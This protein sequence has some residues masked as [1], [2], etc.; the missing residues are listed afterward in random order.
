MQVFNRV[1][2][3]VTLVLSTVSL[4]AAN[5]DQHFVRAERGQVLMS[6]SGTG[7]P[8]TRARAFLSRHGDV[9]GMSADERARVAPTAGPRVKTNAASSDGTDLRM[10]RVETDNIGETHVRMSQFYDGL[11]VFGAEVVVHMNEK[12]ITGVNGAFVAGVDLDVMPRLDVFDAIEVVIGTAVKRGQRAP[13]V[14]TPELIVYR[15]G[16]LEGRPGKSVLAWS[17]DVTTREKSE[18]VILDAQSGAELLRY[19]LRHDALYRKIY[20]PSPAESDLRRKEGDA[21]TL[22]PPVDN[23][24]DFAGQAYALFKNAFGR[25]SYD[26]NG[27]TMRSVYLVSDFCPNAVFSPADDMTM[28][29]PGF[30]TDDVVA[31]EWGHAYTSQTH[32]LIYAYQSGA[33]NESYSDIWGET[34]DL[35]NGR[36]TLLGGTNNAAP[37]PA[38]QRWIIGEDMVGPAHNELLTRDMWDPD[39]LGSPGKVSSPNYACGT[40]DYGG[41]HTNS[42]VPNHAYALLVDGGTYNGQTIS[43]I[44]FNRAAA[45]YYRAMTAYQVP[46]TNFAEHE[47]ALATSCSDLIGKPLRDH[48][49]GLPITEVITSTQCAQ[50][51]KAMR[52][53]EMSELPAQCNYGPQLAAN[54]PPK[55][56]RY[57]TIFA[58]DFESGL[59]GWSL[60]TRGP[61]AFSWT[62]VTNP[63]GRAGSSAFAEDPATGTCGEPG[64]AFTM[65]SPSIVLPSIAAGEKLNLRFDHLV[66]TE[67][68]WDGGN[69]KISVNGGPFTIVPD[70]AYSFNAPSRTLLTATDSSGNPQNTNPLAGERAFTG[71]DGG[72][73]FG[74]WGTSIIDLAAVANAGDSIRIQFDFGFDGCAGI[75][76]WFIDEVSVYSCP[77]VDLR[78]PQLAI[79]DDAY[80]D[81]GGGADRDGRYSITWSQPSEGEPACGFRI[82]EAKVVAV[83]AFTDNAEETLVAG[84]NSKWSGAATWISNQHPSTGTFGYNVVYADNQNASLTLKTPFTIPA[85]AGAVLTFDSFED[86]EE[87]YDNVY[88]DVSANGGATFQQVFMGTGAFSGRRVINLSQFEGKSVLVRFRLSSDLYFSFPLYQGWSI[89]NISI[90]TTD[91]YTTVAN[92]GATARSFD[93]TGRG[94]GLYAY[95]VSALFG[96]C[97]RDPNVG[98]AS[99]VE[100]VTVSL[101]PSAL[102]TSSFTMNPTPGVQNSAVSFNGTA[103]TDN[104]SIG[105]GA[106]I[107][108]YHW[109]FGDGATASGA[110]TSH[111]YTAAGTYRVTLTVTD[112]DGESASSEQLLQVVEPAPT[113]AAGSGQVSVNGGRAS[114][115]FD[116]LEG[117][118]TYQE[119]KL[120]VTAT[121]VT[122]SSRSGS[123]VTFSGACTVNK[124]AGFTYTV[125]AEDGSPD[126]FTITLSDG[127]SATGAVVKGN[128][129]VR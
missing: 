95:R 46:T 67:Q 57:D 25:D 83:P 1:V 120:K 45:I 96:E 85:D 111:T 5:P 128:I 109:S 21:P 101:V 81:Q 58:D 123:K 13:E 80:P 104:D 40:A 53:V 27:R 69:A 7:S 86:V 76:G 29:C 63:H 91:K 115:A 88:V 74:T 99:N 92:V 78:A 129:T 36:D 124:T 37:H 114:F 102:P 126:R 62:T 3:A 28:Y 38:G 84:A 97:D 54:A 17:I 103:S 10:K 119:G 72:K 125:T 82:E 71:T 65:T 68:E 55:C 79:S 121:S 41:V 70:S 2:V 51:Q 107:S 61:R 31:H 113:V 16:L 106:V 34:V 110:T 6:D 127:Y 4:S 100:Q 93:V 122:S 43:A 30:D 112:N 94:N 77:A 89:D 105:S 12:G 47:Q 33:L 35:N 59:D 48:R 73:N 116:M 50:V 108:K 18:R 32:D 11:R 117:S 60:A 118:L 14:S 19:P 44:G 66:E 15:T 22:L 23:L 24:Y 52:A 8:E 9:I 49:T 90:A 56:V 42:G 87:S 64:T 26:G 20:S 98:P 39:R 75:R